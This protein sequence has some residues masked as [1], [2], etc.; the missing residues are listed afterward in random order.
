[1]RFQITFFTTI[2]IFTVF[3]TACSTPETPN[4]NAPNATNGNTNA[5]KTNGDN[6]FT[7]NK[8]PEAPT[9]NTAPTLA[10]VVQAYYNALKKKDDAAVKKVMSQE[11]IKQM[12]ADMKAEGAKSIAAFMADGEILD[13]AVE[14]RNEK[15]EGDKATAE[16]K[17]GTYVN[18]TKFTFVK[19]NGE[20]K[21]TNKF[22]DIDAVKQSVP[23]SNTAK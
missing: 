20:W 23:N 3:L 8:P 10:P 17:G 2:L 19:E 5:P 11:F 7:T 22:E 15:I 21:M 14:V 13:K 9:T 4:V 16:L 1:M 6:R 18:W 12:E